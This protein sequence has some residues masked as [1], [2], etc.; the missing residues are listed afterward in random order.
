MSGV[1]REVVKP[2]CT[3]RELLLHRQQ[4]GTFTDDVDEYCNYID[5]K[6]KEGEPSQRILWTADGRSIQVL[7]QP[8]ADGG[9]V[10][11]LEDFTERKRAEERIARVA[12]YISATRPPH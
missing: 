2:G 9:W 12:D 10:T 11:T 4:T 7:S 8:L 6:L 5:G 1:S 3:F